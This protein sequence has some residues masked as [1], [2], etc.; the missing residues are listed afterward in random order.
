MNK[1]HV[2]YYYLATGMEGIPDQR[3]YGCVL[4]DS[5]EDAVDLI[6]EAEHMEKYREFAKSCLSARKVPT[7]PTR[8]KIRGTHC[9]T[10]GTKL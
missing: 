6:I 5:P 1:Y 4:A 10:C 7:Q 9:P 2:T 3:D 8:T